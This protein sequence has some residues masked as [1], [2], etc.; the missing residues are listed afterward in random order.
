[1]AFQLDV[2]KADRFL[3]RAPVY[4]GGGDEITR[5]QS[6]DQALTGGG[7]DEGAGKETDDVEEQVQNAILFAHYE[8][9]ISFAID[10]GKAGVA[11]L[12]T[13]KV[14][15]GWAVPVRRVYLGEVAC[16]M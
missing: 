7:G 5:L 9:E 14:L 13:S 4:E 12:P 8:I 15:K 1:V 16:W 11:V 3:M 6:F 2:E 10:V